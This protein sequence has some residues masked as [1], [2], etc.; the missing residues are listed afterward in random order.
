MLKSSIV[1]SASFLSNT[2]GFQVDYMYPIGYLCMI[3]MERSWIFG[4]G[5]S[6]PIA[7]RTTLINSSMSNSFIYH[8]SMYW[9]PQTSI[10]I[11]NKQSRTFFWQGG[12]QRRKYHIVRWEVIC[13]SKKKGGLRVKDIWKN[14]CLLCKWWWRLDNESG[15]WQDIV[16]TKYLKNELISSVQPRFDDSPIWKDLMKVSIIYLRG[17][18]IKPGNG[19]KTLLWTVTWVGE[20]PLCSRFSVL[21]ELCNEKKRSR[22][23]GLLSKKANCILGDGYQISS[24][25]SGRRCAC[26][27][28][29]KV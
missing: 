1:K 26:W 24:M 28:W 25:N 22:L 10:N 12:G 13:K 11:L 16:K 9:L 14:L 3:R 27:Y 8:M 15:L 20:I 17:R 4:K 6:M 18:K 21:F 19:A 29:I 7:G 5:G 2:W 23:I